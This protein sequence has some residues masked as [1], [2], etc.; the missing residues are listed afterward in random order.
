MK[1]RVAL[2]G[3]RPAT[4]LNRFDGVG[5]IRGEYV[6]RLAG[7]YSP[8]P[9]ARTTIEAYVRDVA[10]AMYPREV[11]YRLSDME[12][13]EINALPGA[14]VVVHEDN[15]IVGHRG[16]RRGLLQKPAMRA[17][18]QAVANAARDWDN[19]KLFFPNVGTPEELQE[20]ISVARSVGFPNEFGSMIEIPAAALAIDQ[21]I[22]TGITQVTIGMNDLTG[23]TLA[24]WRDSPFYRRDNP[25]VLALAK[26][27]IERG[28]DR[29]I[30]VSI[31]GN[32]RPNEFEAVKALEP[33]FLVVH[34]LQLPEL[35]GMDPAELPDLEVSPRLMEGRAAALKLQ[36][37]GVFEQLDG[38]S[39]A[40]TRD[41]I[42][43]LLPPLQ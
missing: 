28:R 9:K 33:D 40:E 37:A 8:T 25:T 22:D 16:T 21:M 42:G 23:N 34:Y 2:S 6:L 41:A 35:L 12:A 30:D 13:F 20:A 36:R 3:E 14:D 5:L 7:E 15:P 24:A 31:A 17:E 10:A 26:S 11:R 38:K 19:V 18:L 32:F 27:V 1:Y 29:G 39:G 43:S 4:A